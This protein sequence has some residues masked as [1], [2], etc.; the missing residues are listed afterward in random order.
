MKQTLITIYLQP[1]AK[2]SEVSG[3]HG[4]HIKIKVNSP[5]VDGKANEALIL[6]L[7]EF[8]DIQKSK[9]KIVS[10]EKSRIKKISIMTSMNENEIK[11]KLAVK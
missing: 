10:G 4:G 7:S 9:I 5:P 3:I 6:F 8:L 11:S 2:K 1:G